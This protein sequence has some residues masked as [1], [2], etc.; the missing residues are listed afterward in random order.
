MKIKRF[1]ELFDT[2]ELRN[3]HEINYLK[4]DINKIIGD[5]EPIDFKSDNIVR[6]I[7]RI[8]REIPFF[9][10]FK[11]E[12]SGYGFNADMG[13]LEEIDSYIFNVMSEKDYSIVVSLLIKINSI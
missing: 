4:G 5:M 13:F 9:I 3:T 8:S 7:D 6:L 11:D 2:E 1:N 12:V 10:V